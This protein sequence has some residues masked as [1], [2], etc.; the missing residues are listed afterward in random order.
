M[1]KLDVNNID[2]N[3]CIVKR[4]MKYSTFN[5]HL[6]SRWLLLIYIYSTNILYCLVVFL[7]NAC[8]TI[9]SIMDV[10]VI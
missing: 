8:C 2:R 4:M 10:M 9:D 1:G 7:P 5:F 3:I 6:D